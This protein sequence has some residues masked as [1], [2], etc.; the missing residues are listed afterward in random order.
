MIFTEPYMEVTN[1][2]AFEIATTN[3]KAVD[4][5]NDVV[6]QLHYLDVVDPKNGG[7]YKRLRE[8]LEEASLKVA[9]A[10][11]RL[12]DCQKFRVI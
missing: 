11:K 6:T 3:A 9:K 4:D 5:V 2:D 12:F 7:I 8:K 1:E 10:N